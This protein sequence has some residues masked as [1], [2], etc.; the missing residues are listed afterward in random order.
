[1]GALSAASR[2]TSLS[3]SL[4]TPPTGKVVKVEPAQ[5]SEKLPQAEEPLLPCL[6]RCLVELQVL[7][8]A[9]ADWEGEDSKAEHPRLAW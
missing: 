1:M 7:W 3:F 8:P 6:R 4:E 5:S 9:P 2:G